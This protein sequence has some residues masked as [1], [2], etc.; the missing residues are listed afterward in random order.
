M[1]KYATM[2]V[3]SGSFFVFRYKSVLSYD[4]SFMVIGRR[5]GYENDALTMNIFSTVLRRPTNR[6]A[7]ETKDIGGLK[8]LRNMRRK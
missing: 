4:K 8:V 5:L 6:F 2:S 7:A 3:K 1:I